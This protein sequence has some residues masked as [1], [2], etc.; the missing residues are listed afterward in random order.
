MRGYRATAPRPL[1][2]AV[3][4]AILVAGA[5]WAFAP[6][7]AAEGLPV[8]DFIS[9]GGVVSDQYVL[10]VTVIGDL[11]AGQVFYGLDGADPDRA[12]TATALYHYE[13]VM[14]TSGLSE[15]DH[16]VTV[17][18]I[19]TTGANVTKAQTITVD[20]TDPVVGVTSSVPDYV[21]GEY[22][23]TATVT[24]EHVDT[25]GVTLVVDGNMSMSW[26]MEEKGGHF[27]L[28]LDTAAELDCGD[29]TLS[30]Y[31]IDLGGNG[32]WSD[33]VDVKVDNMGPMVN[34]ASEGGHAT[35]IYHLSVNVT[36]C[37]LD[38]D[39]V[40]G[41]FDG[42]RLNKTSLE[43]QG[44][45]VYTYAFDT[46]TMPDGDTEISIVAVDQVGH[47]TESEPLLLNVDNN[48]PVSR[49][50]SEGGNVSGIITIEATVTDAYLN[51]TAVY[52]VL[53]GDDDNSTM[54]DPVDQEGHYQLVV[55]TRDWM[56]GSYELRVWAED[57]WGMYARSPAVYVE[58]DNYAP[59][60][61]FVSD[62]GVRWGDYQVRA[63]VYDPQLNKSCVQL[64]V[65]NGDPLNMREGNEYWYYNIKTTDYPDGPLELMVMAC[66]MKGNMNPGEMMTITVSNRADLEIVSVQ[67]VTQELE[68]G[69]K[70]RVKVTVKNNGHTTVKGYAVSATSGGKT[71][72]TMTEAT[73]IL[74]N[75]EHSYTLEWKT[76]SLGEQVVRLEV[77]PGQAVDESDETNNA[78]QQQTI[79]V[80]EEGS[81]VPGMGVAVALAAVVAVSIA[82]SDRRRR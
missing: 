74:P 82:L 8:I 17:K 63:T 37:Y 76:K 26:A 77:D 40:W 4:A 50:T 1:R 58:V 24:D 68:L 81:S 9:E 41:V 13:A 65:N 6:S 73:G 25:S 36:D 19:N 46:T 21:E 34:F 14:D 49:I 56:D 78:Y 20:L 18:A 2:M 5:M 27:E 10:N 30:V 53:N 45:G 60:I 55:D 32:A 72:A 54:M 67:W 59:V 15:G 31:A 39:K 48:P 42:D 80:S 71:L 75:K 47:E 62:G 66:D 28:V 3:V 33:D 57:E 35:G 79:T 38:A 16:T 12:M 69:E 51:M 43:A 61:E 22:T 23:V 44:E 70:A 7:A 11:A 64:R 29:H 52:L